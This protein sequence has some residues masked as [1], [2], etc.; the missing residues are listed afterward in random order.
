MK[1]TVDF[2]SYEEYSTSDILWSGYVIIHSPNTRI[3]KQVI[4]DIWYSKLDSLA[5]VNNQNKSIKT[6]SEWKCT[7]CIATDVE[8]LLV[9]CFALTT[10][11]QLCL[12]A[13]QDVFWIIAEERV[14]ILMTN[15]IQVP[16]SHDYHVTSHDLLP[17][18]E[19]TVL[20]AR[21]RGWLGSRPCPSIAAGKHHHQ[22]WGKRYLLLGLCHNGP[23]LWIS[24][25]SPARRD[26]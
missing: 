21:H 14:C 16:L 9:K 20:W 24:D 26:N 25:G 1:S 19:S 8:G 4:F 10:C 2:W 6:C 22:F 13:Q 11:S 12:N 18:F 23:I 7:L 3:H 15:T 17:T 5:I